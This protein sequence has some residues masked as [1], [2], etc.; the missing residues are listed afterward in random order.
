MIALSAMALFFVIAVAVAYC[1]G[2]I[3]G[4]AHQIKKHSRVLTRMSARI[5]DA[6]S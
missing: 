4:A 5:K 3:D 6:G 2:R 1:I